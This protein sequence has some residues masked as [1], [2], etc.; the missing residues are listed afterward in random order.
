MAEQK[1]EEKTKEFTAAPFVAGVYSIRGVSISD[2]KYLKYVGYENASGWCRQTY[3]NPKDSKFEFIPE[4]GKWY[5][6][7]QCDDVHCGKYLCWA[8]KKDTKQA[9]YVRMKKNG[10]VWKLKS[11]DKPNE[12]YIECYNIWKDGMTCNYGWLDFNIEQGGWNLLID[13]N[14]YK[15][16]CIY[17]L[18][19]MNFKLIAAI[20]NFDFGNYS[21]V[22]YML[23]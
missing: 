13:T 10:C 5:I 8:R 6:K 17:K 23:K 21:D 1:S 4:N 9:Y 14:S 7:S 3:D 15:S 19:P 22:E 16:T 12:F 20:S 18:T 11:A 2:G